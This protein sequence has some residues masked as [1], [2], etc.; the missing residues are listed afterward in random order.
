MLEESEFEE[1]VVILEESG[2]SVE[3]PFESQ[4]AA[5]SSPLT[6][7]ASAPATL[8]RRSSSRSS[9]GGAGQDVLPKAAALRRSSS[10]SGGGGGIPAA[11]RRALD[12]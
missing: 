1:S 6:S 9:S 11:P 3:T 10:G 2:V 5:R 7:E 12:L 4:S 8:L